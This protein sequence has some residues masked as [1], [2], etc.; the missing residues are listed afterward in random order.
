MHYVKKIEG[1]AKTTFILKKNLN[2]NIYVYVLT[3]KIYH[4]IYHIS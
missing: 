2:M 3:Y 1:Q 4:E